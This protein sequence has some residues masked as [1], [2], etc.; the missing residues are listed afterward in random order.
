M[1]DLILLDPNLSLVRLN[2]RDNELQSYALTGST[3]PKNAKRFSRAYVKRDIVQNL[4]RAERLR[5]VIESHCRAS[6]IDHKAL[7][8]NM[9][10]MNLIKNTS[11]RIISSEET[12]TLVVA[13]RPTP[14]APSFVV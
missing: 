4:L 10:K 3:A 5:H 11:T 12:T 7:P 14:C 9:K 1:R 6:V 8:G 2:E 13:A